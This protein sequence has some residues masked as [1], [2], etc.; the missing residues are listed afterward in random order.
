M[1]TVLLPGSGLENPEALLPAH[2]RNA[3]LLGNHLSYV[4]VWVLHACLT[5]RFLAKAEVARWPG[6]G[7]LARGAGTLFVDRGA[8]RGVHHA[9]SDLAQALE[10][11][12]EE[13]MPRAFH[14]TE[15]YANNRVE[16]DHGRLK[17]RLR[18][19]V[20]IVET[21]GQKFGRS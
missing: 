18:H 16:C 7:I 3:V 17:A 21:H 19:V 13:L 20:G 4:D 12:I 9:G 5:G 14:N 10:T 8:H 15:H 11:A 1:A 2:E 6:I